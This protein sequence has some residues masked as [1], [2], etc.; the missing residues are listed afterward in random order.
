M[1]KRKLN[2]IS[3]NETDNIYSRIIKNNQEVA[4]SLEKTGSKVSKV[5]E[6]YRQ[7]SVESEKSISLWNRVVTKVFEI[8]KSSIPDFIGGHLED[9]IEKKLMAAIE[10]VAPKNIFSALSTLGAFKDVLGKIDT[11][12]DITNNLLEIGKAAQNDYTIGTAVDGLSFHSLDS[13]NKYYDDIK[14]ARAKDLKGLSETNRYEREIEYKQFDTV[15]ALEL[16]RYNELTDSRNKYDETRKAEFANLDWWMKVFTQKISP[17]YSL[18]THKKEEAKINDYY[19]NEKKYLKGQNANSFWLDQHTRSLPEVVITKKSRPINKEQNHNTIPNSNIST[20]E[21]L[22]TPSIESIDFET[23]LL[24]QVEGSQAVLAKHI[25]DVNTK[26]TSMFQVQQTMFTIDLEKKLIDIDSY[27]TQEIAKIEGNETAISELKTKHKAARDEASKTHMKSIDDSEKLE[28]E[29]LQGM[30]S[31]GMTELV[32]EQ[33]LEITRKYIEKRI[34]AQKALA[35]TGNE[36]AKVQ[37]D[38][39]EASLKNLELKKPAQSLKALADKALFNTI[40]KGFEKIDQSTEDST[41]KTENAKAKTIGLFSTITGNAGQVSAVVK[42]LKSAFGGMDEGLDMVLETVGNIA[43]GFATGGMVG[44]I[45]AVVSEGFSLLGKAKDAEKRHQAA[46]KAISTSRITQQREYNLLLMEQNLLMKE[47]TTIFGE[48]QISK[49]A[50]SVLV[51]QQALQ[52][53]NKE[54]KGTEPKF[55]S[56]SSILKGGVKDYTKQLDAYN[57]GIGGL[58][59]AQIVTGHKKSGLFGWGKGKDTYSSIVDVYGYDELI[60]KEGKLN[61]ER[62]KTIISTQKMSD[63]TKSYLQNLIDLQEKAEKAE[64]ALESYLQTTFGSL[65]TDLMKSITD[66]LRSDGVNAWEEFGKAGAG[67]LEKLGEQLAYELFFAD[68]FEALQNDL[69]KVYSDTES[70]NNPEERSKEIAK[71]QMAVVGSFYGSIGTEMEAAQVFLEEWKNNGKNQGFSMWSSAEATTRQGATGSGITS[72]SENTA[73][74]LNGSFYA[75]RQQV[76]DITNISRESLL[77]QRTMQTQLTRVADNT[78]YCR[79]LENV[80]NS[81]EDI[82]TRGVRIKD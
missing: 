51:Y 45:M 39:L 16:K 65:G 38:I 73:S 56:L 25:S 82:Q 49:A 21:P 35:S 79:Y 27:Y 28:L 44:G 5:T 26:L 60:D 24:N 11:A 46:L 13:W 64:E 3:D 9:S 2:S 43:A 40:Q 74:E 4:T 7:Q 29:R 76:G 37:V 18:S 41:Q 15:M 55:P 34:E 6:Q 69:K 81:L 8:A 32:E 53:M 10:K 77:I 47:A 22:Q 80:K 17:I 75:I 42:D 57:K 48:K 62:V 50:K 14:A 19:D 63:E 78:E 36:T 54:I 33:K 67:V 1:A 70:I 12:Q 61:V 72:M 23:Q 30:Q 31:I 58:Y 71:K 59:N 52:N 66:A 20:I 68:K